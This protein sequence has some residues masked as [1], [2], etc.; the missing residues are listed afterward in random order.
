MGKKRLAL[1]DED[2]LDVEEL[3]KNEKEEAQKPEIKEEPKAPIPQ[4][5]AIKEKKEPQISDIPKKYTENTPV[6]EERVETR[7]RKK[8]PNKKDMT[9]ISLDLTTETKRDLGLLCFKYQKEHG[10]KDAPK[11]STLIRYILEDEVEKNKDYI[12]K[13]KVIL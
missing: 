11:L 12:E 8:D 3:E 10:L 4:P 9:K 1:S 7:G 13:A 2:F 6:S 5:E